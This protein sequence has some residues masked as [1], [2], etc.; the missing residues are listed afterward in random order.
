MLN[1][2]AYANGAQDAFEKLAIDAR[3][4]QKMQSIYSHL[5]PEKFNQVL[6]NRMAIDSRHQK[7][8][9][10]FEAQIA[11]H[12]KPE[13]G[14]PTGIVAGPK[15]ISF[16]REQLQSMPGEDVH[17]SLTGKF[18]APPLEATGQINM[19]PLVPTG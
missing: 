14:E 9:P 5:P 2:L 12:N 15:S 10:N 8:S 19:R 16:N 11:A 7:V 17:R 13:V 3:T 4:L 6:K 18:P 1:E